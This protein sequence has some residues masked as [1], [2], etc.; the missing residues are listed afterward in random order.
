[1]APLCV[2][3]LA[4]VTASEIQLHL[5]KA[6][7]PIWRQSTTKI[8]D[9]PGTLDI[10]AK[11]LK[12]VPSDTFIRAI[13]IMVE[14]PPWRDFPT[15]YDLKEYIAKVCPREPDRNDQPPEY[16][17]DWEKRVVEHPMAPQWAKWPALHSVWIY[18]KVNG[19]FPDEATQEAY[20]SQWR[21][22]LE[23]IGKIVANPDGY[24]NPTQLIDVAMTML[25]RGALMARN[26]GVTDSPY[27]VA[28]LRLSERK[29]QMAAKLQE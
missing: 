5:F 3:G 16:F 9:E 28:L 17:A 25:S 23:E 26:V 2:L 18:C 11:S 27:E 19:R 4:M 13:D 10:W 24:L 20:K 21:P 8:L 29:T 6:T 22:F 1:M 7:R 15:P 12:H 14:N